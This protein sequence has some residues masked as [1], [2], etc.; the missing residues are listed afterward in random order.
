MV[1]EAVNVLAGAGKSSPTS[2]LFIQSIIEGIKSKL[3]IPVHKTLPMTVEML[4]AIVED[5]KKNYS[6][7]NIWLASACLLAFVGFLRFDE[8]GIIKVCELRDSGRLTYSRIREL[9]K[10][11]ME[12]LGFLSKYFSLHSRW[13][14][15]Q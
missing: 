10:A 11:K 15:M 5:T 13:S 1:E 6:L 8:L 2:S 3:A 14:N 9:L 7:A 12:E 4:K